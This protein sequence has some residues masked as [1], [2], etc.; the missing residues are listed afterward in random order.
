M[1]LAPPHSLYSLSGASGQTVASEL[2]PWLD[3]GLLLAEEVALAARIAALDGPPS[4]PL[5]LAFALALRAD[6]LGSAL[7]D[8]EE[9]DVSRML[10]DREYRAPVTVSPTLPE[11]ASAWLTELTERSAL[12]SRAE[13]AVSGGPVGPVA[14]APFVLD[15]SRLY[16]ARA[17]SAESR[18]AGGVGR[19]VHGAP[20]VASEA[21]DDGIAAA[22]LGLIAGEGA[23]HQRAAA[24]SALAPARLQIVTGGPGTGKTYTVRAML[25]LAWLHRAFPAGVV[26]TLD[27]QLAA[28]TGKAAQRMKEA[29]GEG[30]DAWCERVSHAVPSG[31]LTGTLCTVGALRSALHTFLA[32]LEARTLHRLLGYQYFNPTRFQHDRHNPLSAD[33]VVVDEASMVDL[34]MMAHLFDAVGDSARLVLVGDRRQLASVE[35]GTVFAD[36]CSWGAGDGRPLVALKT[37]RRFPAE[38][39]VGRFATASEALDALEPVAGT[40]EGARHRRGLEAAGKVADI[41]VA[42]AEPSSTAANGVTVRWLDRD[43]SSGGSSRRTGSVTP[44][45][46]GNGA[47]LDGE[48]DRVADH[49][50]GIMS[51]LDRCVFQVGQGGAC[52]VVGDNAAWQGLVER[53]GCASV[54]QAA[55]PSEVLARLSEQVRILA[56]HREGVRGVAGLNREVWRRIEE[57]VRALPGGQKPAGVVGKAVG[58]P[59]VGKPIIVRKNDY[60]L[61]RYNGD[62]GIWVKVRRS[63]EASE[64]PTLMALFAREGG[65]AAVAVHTS[66][67]LPE[68]DVVW[69]MTVHKSQGSEF[70]KVVFVLPERSTSLWTRE[71]IY[72]GITRVKRELVLAGSRD[73]LTDGLARR[74]R[75]ASGL[76]EHFGQGVG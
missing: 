39:A 71:L 26:P 53:S 51:A 49:W 61:G 4:T 3:S 64:K 76:L 65:G 44:S 8:L 2:R 41:L 15:G 66:S 17:W 28:P 24:R 36:L 67:R 18:V 9:V 72:T 6:R 11:P 70:D 68:H 73:V 52:T 50:V 43:A 25:T 37:S 32:N 16:T 40:P 69:A 27:V 45:S 1:R 58:E 14:S 7:V 23:E 46:P 12:V 62:V 55:R 38:S 22:V 21:E 48:L 19:M 57:K 56:A 33:L 35:T 60:G 34:T 13:R 47:E 74:I 42:A 31:V 75:R 10:E 29:M 54:G 63:D 30:L 59:G 20:R 5:V